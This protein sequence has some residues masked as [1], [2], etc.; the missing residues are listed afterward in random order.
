[1]TPPEAIAAPASPSRSTAAG[2]DEAPA[3][4]PVR[5]GP[6]AT[7]VKYTKI[8]RVSLIERMTYRGD[9]LFGTILRFLP[10][11][12]TILLWKAVYE[13]SG[14][15]SLGG[16]QYREMIAYLLLTNISDDFGVTS[17]ALIGVEFR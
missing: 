1:M 16:F 9:F 10:I 2:L 7:L 11:V 17:D 14:Q 3:L 15:P 6:L 13:S 5:R 4:A 12:T 8:F